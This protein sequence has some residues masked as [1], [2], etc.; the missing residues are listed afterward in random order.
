MHEFVEYNSIVYT[1]I[2]ESKV[3]NQGI[4]ARGGCSKIDILLYVKHHWRLPRQRNERMT[5]NRKRLQSE[6][7]YRGTI[8]CIKHELQ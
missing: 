4:A 2:I 3:D 7:R 1:L 6:R 5:H 8:I